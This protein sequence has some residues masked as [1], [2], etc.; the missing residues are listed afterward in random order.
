MLQF[1]VEDCTK[2][3]DT[4]LLPAGVKTALKS[5]KADGKMLVSL[6]ATMTSVPGSINE[7]KTNLGCKD[8]FE[9]LLFF[10]ELEKM[11]ISKN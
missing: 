4:S 10:L 8:V 1:A 2:W 9:F 7:F 11:L 6:Y 5:K 3:I